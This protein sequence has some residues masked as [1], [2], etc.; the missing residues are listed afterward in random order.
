MAKD[1]LPKVLHEVFGMHLFN[2]H[3]EVPRLSPPHIPYYTGGSNLG[4]DLTKSI[5]EEDQHR[6]WPDLL[7]GGNNR[8]FRTTFSDACCPPSEE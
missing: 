5:Q 7:R 4:P 3:Q 6:Q 2:T 1:I 8:N